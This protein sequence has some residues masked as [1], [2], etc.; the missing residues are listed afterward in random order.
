MD[1]CI[2]IFGA[3]R[4]SRHEDWKPAVCY[5]IYSDPNRHRKIVE[6]SFQYHLGLDLDYMK[7]HHPDHF[8]AD[9]N[10]ARAILLYHYFRERHEF[11][12]DKHWEFIS[13]NKLPNRAANAE[14]DDYEL[15]VEE[16]N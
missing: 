5:V 2:K 8:T 12:A 6:D 15:W 11:F 10:V 16:K 4:T 13:S 14:G 9:H 7:N 3:K 1:T